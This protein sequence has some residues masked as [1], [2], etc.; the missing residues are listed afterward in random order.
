MGYDDGRFKL[1]MWCRIMRDN[2]FFLTQLGTCFFLPSHRQEKH[3]RTPQQWSS[4][5]PPWRMASSL[6][7]LWHLQL[8]RESRSLLQRVYLQQNL[9]L[10]TKTF[11]FLPKRGLWTTTR[12]Y[13]PTLAVKNGFWEKSNFSEAAIVEVTLES[14]LKAVL[15]LAVIRILMSEIC[16]IVSRRLVVMWTL[17]AEEQVSI[18]GWDIQQQQQHHLD[19]WGL[20]KEPQTSWKV[21][22][23]KLKEMMVTTRLSTLFQTLLAPVLILSNCSLQARFLPSQ[24]ILPCCPHLHPARFLPS[25]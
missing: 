4:P 10:N 13:P 23:F 17:A 15:L 20:S 2:S 3:T 22:R 12:S 21:S 5:R 9:L 25:Q 7:C 6:S 1:E 16:L 18:I 19:V 8:L 24:N 11:A 14:L